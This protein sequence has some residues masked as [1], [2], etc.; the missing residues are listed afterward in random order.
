MS[1]NIYTIEDIIIK[2]KPILKK[3]K[4]KEAFIFGS[5]A[6]NMAKKDSDIDFLIT[7]PSNFTLVDMYSLEE[8][9]KNIFKKNI[10]LVSN[11]SYTRDMDKE[12]SKDGIKAK[13]LFYKEIMNERKIIYG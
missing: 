3:Y 2:S 13:Q 5:Y 9:L 4:I 6:K 10:D 8:E 11:N 7:P 12:I 1:N